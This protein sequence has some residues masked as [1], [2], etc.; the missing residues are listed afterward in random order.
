M[1]SSL[2]QIAARRFEGVPK[3]TN[4]LDETTT[5]RLLFAKLGKVTGDLCLFRLGLLLF[6]D[7]LVDQADRG[8]QIPL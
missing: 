7:R 4:E 3:V 1:R 8:L 5:A 6:V 2:D